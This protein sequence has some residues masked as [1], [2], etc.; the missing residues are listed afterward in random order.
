[1]K[2]VAGVP[3]PVEYHMDLSMTPKSPKAGEKLR[4]QFDVREPWKEGLVTNFATV[5]ERL[6]HVFFVS[7]NL[8][9]FA[10]EH[11]TWEGDSFSHEIS[12]PQPGMYRVLADFYPEAATPQL[13]TKTI[14]VAGQEPPVKP[15]VRD[16][17]AKAAENL[18]IEF[19]T[20]PATP[21]A[22]VL[23]QMRF[24]LTPGE[25][26]EKYLGAWGHMLVASDDLIDLI[27]TH[28][29]LADGSPELQFNLVFPRGRTY[30]VWVQF[31]RD[32]VVNTAH[33]DVPVL[34]AGSDPLGRSS[35]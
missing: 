17:A 14:F 33:F 8:Q 19:A 21:V 31:Q 12:L 26:Y 18:Q 11:P 23:T 29:A 25:G 28:P 32:G 22:G 30:R 7:R 2:L 4:L 20:N 5:H 16:Y 6:F 1:M 34:P 15:L 35:H 24:K 13:I 3:D 27:H 10:H 9:F